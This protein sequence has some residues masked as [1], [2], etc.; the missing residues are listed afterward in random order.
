MREFIYDQCLSSGREY[1]GAELIAIAN[2]KLKAR[3]MKPILSRSTFAHDM[4]EMNEKLF[5]AY[6]HYNILSTRRNGNKV[7]YC[8]KNCNESLY[9]NTLSEED[10]ERLQQICSLML[11][12]SGMPHF[13]W[14]DQVTA[15]LYQHRRPSSHTIACFEGTTD[16]DAQY[17]MQ[18]FDAIAQHKALNLC[19]KKF[20][21]EPTDRIIHPYYLKQYR[22]RWYLFAY[23]ER[24]QQI[25]CFALDRME[26]LTEAKE[27]EYKT[28]DIDF[29]HYLDNVIGVTMP[30][31]ASIERIRLWADHWVVNYLRTSPLHHSQQIEQAEDGSSIVTLDVMINHELEQEIL[32][33]GE[34]V[35]VLAPEHFCLQLATRYEQSL[36]LIHK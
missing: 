18:L 29:N 11:G 16:R 22:Q 25:V 3:D 19:Y 26:S 33:L 21:A 34:H 15:R 8:Y 10:M 13:K 30:Q 35:S 23:D 20:D 5:M 6:G 32:F 17:F 7:Y 9:D 31:H 1:T 4:E 14:I 24:R 28:T 2:R 36:K 12:F 27:V